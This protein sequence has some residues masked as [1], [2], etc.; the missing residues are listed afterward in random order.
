MIT[1]REE[2]D[3]MVR[4]VFVEGMKVGTY[5]A[6]SLDVSECGLCMVTNIDLKPGDAITIY[7]KDLWKEPMKAVAVWSAHVVSQSNRV[8]LSLCP[9]H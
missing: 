5:S 9:S 6:L 2:R 7:S 4:P 3:K 1:R 8:G